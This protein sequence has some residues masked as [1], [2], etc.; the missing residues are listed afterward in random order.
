MIITFDE[1]AHCEVN[2]SSCILIVYIHVLI[3]ISEE[4]GVLQS[5]QQEY[6]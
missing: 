6:I 3:C 4:I 2:A 1:R 5:F